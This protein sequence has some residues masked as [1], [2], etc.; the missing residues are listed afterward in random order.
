MTDL[1]RAGDVGASRTA[2][3][4]GFIVAALPLPHALRQ[5]LQKTS[6]DSAVFLGN[7]GITFLIRLAGAG[8]GFGLQVL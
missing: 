7:A 6:S 5:H 8:L 4:L 1:P 2:T 3:A